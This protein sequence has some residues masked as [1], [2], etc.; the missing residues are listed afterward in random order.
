MRGWAH[1]H[2]LGGKSLADLCSEPA[3]RQLIADELKKFGADFKGYERIENFA[4]L[5]EEFTSDNGMLTPSLKI[6]RNVVN[7]RFKDLLESL[8]QGN[9]QKV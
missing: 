3:V 5:S 6:K 7:E 8:Y 4:L 1:P 2:G 9:N